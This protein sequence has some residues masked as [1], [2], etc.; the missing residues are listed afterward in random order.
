MVFEGLDMESYYRDYYYM[1][2]E[3]WRFGYED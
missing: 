1:K 2:Q 3:D